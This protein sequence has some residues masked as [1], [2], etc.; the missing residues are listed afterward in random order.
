MTERIG[1]IAGSGRFP[2]LFAETARRRGVEVFAVAHRDETD[3]ELERVVAGIAWIF[4]GELDAMIGAL[5]GFAVRRAVMVGG[6]TK[7]RLFRE[8]RPDA[9]AM[10]LI[11]R[12]GQVRDDLVLRAV[13]AELES[14]GIAVVA[15]TVYLQEIVPGPGVLGA[16]APTPDEWR[17]IHF[18]FR[19]AKVIGQFDIGQSVVVRSGAVIAVEGIEGT[20]ATIRR[21]GELANGDVVL[22]KVCKPTQ[23]TR[24][25]L[26]AVGPATVT[27]LAQV[28]GRALA[29]EAGSTVVLDRDEMIALANRA[30]IAVVA[31]DG[32]EGGGG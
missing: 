2:V 3:P 31:L 28:N 29:I 5:R 8:F 21:A 13:A 15:S 16:R 11:A 24:F 20:D 26:P 9:R 22:V 6:I 19:A 27:A 30:D 32:K 25:D 14:E 10:A 18:G 1:L 23:D 17:D 4:P 7:R 12:V